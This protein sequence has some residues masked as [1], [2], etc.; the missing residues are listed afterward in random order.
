MSKPSRPS[1]PEHST[2]LPR[3]FFVTSGTAQGKSLFQSERMANLFIDVLRSNVQKQKFIIHDF[4]IMPNHIHVLMTVPGEM[5]LE[6]A[7]RLIKGSFSFRAGSELGFRAEI[8]QRGFSDVR[9]TDQQ[10]FRRHQDYINLN[11]VKA[12]LAG[13][14][15]EYGFG[16]AYLKKQKRM[17]HEALHP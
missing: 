4:V 13:S 14:P 5:S 6:K 7:I 12:D 10:S 16:S 2:G 3:T 15:E 11:P 17:Q 9:I 8:W 1:D